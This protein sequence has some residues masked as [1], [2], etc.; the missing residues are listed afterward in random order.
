MSQIKLIQFAKQYGA[1]TIFDPI[2]VEFKRGHIYGIVGKNG[3]GKSTLFKCIAGLET[4]ENSIDTTNLNIGFLPTEPYSINKITG[5]EYL[6]LLT[7]ARKIEK[8][9]INKKNIF[10]LP[11]NEYIE[12]YSTGMMKK[13]ALMGLLLQ[14]NDIFLL[15]EPFNGLDLESNLILKEIIEVLKR[16]NKIVLISSHMLENLISIS[17]TIYYI[18][19]FKIKELADDEHIKKLKSVLTSNM[20]G[21]LDDLLN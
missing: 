11:L 6:T 13:I 10:N 12:N 14:K 17:D 1:K 5:N 9:N 4:Y 2:S 20:S 21:Q 15:D 16:K 7:S 3:S 18:D 19:E 8:G